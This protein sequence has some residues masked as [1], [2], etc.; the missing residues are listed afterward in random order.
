MTD[1]LEENKADAEQP[2]KRFG[3]TFAKVLILTLPPSVLPDRFPGHQHLVF[4]V[5]IIGGYLVQHFIPPRGRYFLPLLLLTLVT[6]A[7]N[8]LFVK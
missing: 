7:L 2:Q 6:V 4:A 1:M 5:T 8:V 3:S